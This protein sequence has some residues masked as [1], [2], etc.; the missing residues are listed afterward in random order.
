MNNITPFT[1][2]SLKLIGIILILSS[3]L[4]YILLAL[5]FNPLES[6]WQIAYIGTVVDR[7]IVPLV[8]I[9]FVL[10][11][12]WVDSTTGNPKGSGIDVKLPMFFLASLL[13][14]VFLLFIPLYLNNLRTVS[15]DAQE[16]IS[17]R[18]EEVEQRLQGEFDQL[19]QLLTD[20]NRIR[21]LDQNIQQINQAL[22][23]GQIQGQTLN[24]QQRQQLEQQKQRLEGLRN[25]QGKPEEIEQRLNELQTQLRGQRLEQENLAKTETLKQGLRIGLSSLML[26][27]CYSVVG[28]IGL[29]NSMG[30]QAPRSR[31]PKR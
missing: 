7:G 13:G 29:K 30:G 8:G 15:A 17:Q 19:N 1:S 11:A 10:A 20:Q 26:A 16:Q 12:Y 23:S 18:A 3:L 5:P 9:A 24:P 28:W 4:D 14:L 31:A 27:G 25:L 6:R 22:N 2:L 21:E